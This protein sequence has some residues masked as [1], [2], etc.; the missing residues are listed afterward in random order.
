MIL[1][2]PFCLSQTVNFSCLKHTKIREVSANVWY[3]SWRIICS[4]IFG[5]KGEYTLTWYAPPL[6]ASIKA[7]GL[8]ST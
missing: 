5:I 6:Q 4:R 2:N 8:D 3:I 1:A 7:S